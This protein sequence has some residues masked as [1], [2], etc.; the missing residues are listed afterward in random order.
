[1]IAD[2]HNQELA[3]IL[4]ELRSFPKETAWVEFKH[5]NSNPN[6]IGEYI[7]ALSNSAAL[8]GK[9]Q[10]WLVWGVDN[11]THDVIGTEFR[12]ATAEVGGE[13]LESWLLRLLTPRIQF[14]FYQFP[15][16]SNLVVM[17]EISAATQHPVSFKNVE[18]IRIGSYKK[19]LKDFPEKERELWRIFDHKHFEEEIAA[20]QSSAED[21]LAKLNYPAYFDLLRLPL[22]EGRDGILVALEADGMITRSSGGRWNITNL[23]GILFAKQLSDFR[24]LQ[25]KSIRVVQYKDNSRLATIRELDER[26]GYAY[27][28]NNL[29]ERMDALLPKNEII[30]RAYR[31]EISMFPP[32]A[33]RELA[34]NAI[35]H[36]DFQISGTSP[37]IEIFSDRLEITNPGLPL[38]K[39]ERFLDSPP[40]S[41]N[42]ILAAFMRRINICEERGSGVDK[43]VA[44]TEAYQLPAPLFETTAQ[45]TRAVLFAHKP[46]RDMDKNDRIRACYLHACLKYVQRQY[47][48]NS[49]LRERLAIEEANSAMVSRIINEAIKAN[50]I[51]VYDESAGSRAR[52]YLPAWAG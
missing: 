24:G 5:N 26:Q 2:S 41:R 7:S 46:L 27:G 38:V 29:I 18:Y 40:R 1:M 23:G 11:A 32:E 19:P 13:E 39:T 21:V 15:V 48:T 51:K 4:H 10:G 50:C 49:S 35:I 14:R 42:E 9:V 28:F 43:V 25:R 45:H 31:R 44:A 22:P 20:E 34:A 37:M 3:A 8:E 6:E 47:M 52:K 17:L 16:E 30:S 12:Y 33:M 36:Q